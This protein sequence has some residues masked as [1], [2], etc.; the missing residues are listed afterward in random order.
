MDILEKAKNFVSEKVANM[1]T[2][3]ATITDV[4]LKGFGLDGITLLA[5]ICVS[6]PY[7]VAIPIG[8]IVYTVKSAGK[9]IVSGSI[10]DPGSLKAN[11]KTMLE[12]TVKVPHSAVVSLARDIGGDWDID[13]LLELGLIVDLPVIGNFTIPMSYAGEMKLPTFSDL[14]MGKSEPEKEVEK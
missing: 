10:P 4:D 3:E 1:P 7:S 13:Y 14:F 9:G 5:K 6:N 12:V 11:D 2:P 8:E